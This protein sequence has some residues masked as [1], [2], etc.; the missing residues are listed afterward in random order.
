MDGEDVYPG[1]LADAC[2]IMDQQVE[3]GTCSGA[4]EQGTGMA[5]NVLDNNNQ[6]R[7]DDVHKED[8]QQGMPYQNNVTCW[9]C[10]K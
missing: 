2:D 3:I 9:H 1:T 7:Q 4:Y 10:N 6:N 5:F 8:S